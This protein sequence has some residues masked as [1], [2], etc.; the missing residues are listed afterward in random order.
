M[1]SLAHTRVGIT[2]ALITC[3]AIDILCDKL[4]SPNEQ[5]RQVSAIA[6]GY[7]TYNRTASRLLLHNCRNVTHLFGVLTSTLKPENKIAKQFIES[8]QTAMQQGLPKLLVNGKL[9]LIDSPNTIT[10]R[11]ETFQGF[12]RGKGVNF[13]KRLV[14]ELPYMSEEYMLNEHNAFEDRRDFKTR[15]MRAQSAPIKSL[16]KTMSSSA[17]SSKTG[18]PVENKLQRNIS[19]KSKSNIMKAN[20]ADDRPKTEANF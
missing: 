18:I 9:K 13:E 15:A 5:I 1:S 10:P 2:D 3:D 6:L 16:V 17:H 20:L 14:H 7:L 19:K 12:Y 11:E 4:Y 8:Y